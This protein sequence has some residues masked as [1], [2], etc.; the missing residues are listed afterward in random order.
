MVNFEHISH[1]VPTGKVYEIIISSL[2]PEIMASIFWINCDCNENNSCTIKEENF[3]FFS[4]LKE[5]TFAYFANKLISSI[6]L[7]K[8]FSILQFFK[9]FN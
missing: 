1:L 4:R 7:R 2:D 3:K 5:T 6:P 9:D 8:Q